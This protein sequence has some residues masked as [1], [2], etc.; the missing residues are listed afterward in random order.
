MSPVTNT[1]PRRLAWTVG[2]AA[3]TAGKLLCNPIDH[4]FG[5]DGEPHPSVAALAL[6]GIGVVTL[7]AVAGAALHLYGTRPT[8][9]YLVDTS[10]RVTAR[11]L[12]RDMWRPAAYT[13]AIAQ[14]AGFGLMFSPFGRHTN[15]RQS[16]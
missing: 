9:R 6:G 4:A 14:G 5:T 2:I 10:E 15:T 16:G 1:V 3:F 13:A 11:W 12:F 7:G 8:T